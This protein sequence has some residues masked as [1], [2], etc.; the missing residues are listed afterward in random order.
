VVSMSQIRASGGR[1]IGRPLA[2]IDTLFYPLLLLDGL[3]VALLAA[4]IATIPDG[5]LALAESLTWLGYL[6]V[7]IVD[8][9][10][11]AIAWRKLR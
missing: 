1:L 5:H 6:L 2:L 4:V 7:I 10:V 3:L 8:L 9:L 11:A